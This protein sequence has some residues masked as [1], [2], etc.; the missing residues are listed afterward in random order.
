MFSSYEM[1]T[2]EADAYVAEEVD[3]LI[4]RGLEGGFERQHLLGEVRVMIDSIAGMHG[5]VYDTEPE[6]NIAE[7]INERL[8][9]PQGWLPISRHDW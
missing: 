2:D 8:C 4:A 6:A 5:E 9:K 3:A 1:Y 7:Q